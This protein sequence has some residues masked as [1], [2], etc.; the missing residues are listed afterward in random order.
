[1]KSLDVTNPPDYRGSSGWWMLSSLDLLAF[2]GINAL[3]V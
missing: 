3:A 1:M 2:Q